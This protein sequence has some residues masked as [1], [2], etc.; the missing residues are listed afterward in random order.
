[1]S[2]QRKDVESE[3]FYLTFLCFIG[4]YNCTRT[5]PLPPPI[6]RQCQVTTRVTFRSHPA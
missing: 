1:M 4:R 5:Q 2:G 6:A 3:H